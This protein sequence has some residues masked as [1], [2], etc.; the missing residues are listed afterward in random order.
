MATRTEDRFG[1]VASLGTTYTLVGAAVPGGTTWNVLVNVTNR[2]ATPAKLQLFIA[3][4]SWSSGE[5]TSGALKAAIAYNTVWQPG[6][7]R[8]ISG[9][10]MK[11]GE[12]L[13]ARSDT[14]ASLDVT[15]NGIA[16][17]P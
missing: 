12:K 1:E 2:A 8:Q 13:V 14:A 16:I 4:G 10:I 11:A 5:P 3:D 17:T 9:F 7:V 6:D 15:A